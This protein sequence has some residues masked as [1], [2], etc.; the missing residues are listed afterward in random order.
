[1]KLNRAQ[2]M[3]AETAGE[4]R[5]GGSHYRAATT[6][7]G[8][9]NTGESSWTMLRREAKV[10]WVA[11]GAFEW[12][13]FSYF[14]LSSV[15]IILFA[16]HLQHPW[17][18]LAWR[19]TVVCVVL[20]L[21]R[22]QARR[23][24]ISRTRGPSFISGWWHFWRH[25]YPHLFFLYCF[26]ELAHLMTL[27]TPHWQDARL[28]A[29]DHWLTG[30]HPSIWLEQFATPGRNE[31]M[32][33][34]YL[35][36][37][38]YLLVLGGILYYRQEWHAYWSVMAY[39]MAGY[40]IGYFIAM[41]F[42]IESPWFSM[43]GWWKEPLHGGPFTATVN[44]IEHYGRVRGAAFPSE[45]VAGSIAVLWGAWRFRRWLFWVLA[46]TVFLMCVSTIWGRYHYIADIFGGIVTGTLGYVIGS[47]VMKRK[48]A[49][50]SGAALG[51]S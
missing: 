39:S 5:T 6:M 11:C 19:A 38:V 42:P 2:E 44:F 4:A 15:P 27:I 31:F 9:V 17:R 49:V 36:Y 29:F 14:A 51:Q 18:M 45:H 22:I 26:E 21:C 25:W 50:A 28:I 34:V 48:G 20:L 10:T 46:P 40:S 33:L 7:W 24:E 3:H 37:F 47:W 41:S 13:A 30:V 43:A 16:E 32:Q 12:L 35:T 1:M 8:E 23:A